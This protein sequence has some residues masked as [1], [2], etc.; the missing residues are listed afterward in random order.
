MDKSDAIIEEN[1][2]MITAKRICTS[3]K[4]DHSTAR[5]VLKQ[6]KTNPEVCEKCKIKPC[7]FTLYLWGN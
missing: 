1:F 2:K 3:Q 6:L 4:L 7:I 5:K